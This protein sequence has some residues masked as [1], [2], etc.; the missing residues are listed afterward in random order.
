[1]FKRK[2]SFI[3]FFV[4]LLTL[5]LYHIPFFK[6]VLANIDLATNSGRL[7]LVNLVILAVCLNALVVYILFNLLR[8]GAKVFLALTFNI[9]AVAIYFINTYHVMI[10][11][12]MVG[13]VFNT[14]YGEASSFFSIPLLG[15]ILFLG[16]IPSIIVFKFEPIKEHFKSF[17]L[18]T[19]LGLVLIGAFA[20]ANSSSWLWID[21]H[22]TVLG[23]LCMPWSYIVNTCRYF[24]D[25]YQENREETLLPNLT[26]RDNKKS[27]VVLVIGES[28]RQQNFSLYGYDKET[29][30]LL[31]QMEDLHVYKAE[32]SATYTTAG[33][34]AILDYKDTGHYY[35]PL[36]NYLKRNGITVFWRSSNNGQPKLKV[37]SYKDDSNLR[38]VAEA[39]GLNADYDEVLLAGL[40][41]D[42]L[43]SQKDKVFVVLH[44]S[45]SHGPTY[46][47]KYPSQFEKFAPVCT[48]VELS[49]CSQEELI[50]AYDNTIVYTDY[51]LARLIAE[52]KELKDYKST[53]M[54]VSDHGESLG[55]SNLYM[56]GVPKKLAP[57]EQYEIPFLVW[58]SDKSLKFKAID[59]INQHFVFHSVLDFLGL[60]SPI[61]NEE[62]S[63]LLRE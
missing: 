31:G 60:D 15:Y 5:A 35:E 10:D 61:Y 21:K 4:S 24:S 40:K 46:A 6:F 53:V 54:F 23:S 13:N 20:F 1:M 22:A 63:L 34:K 52:V 62:S 16:I 47:K 3:A 43:N 57:K 2:L 12:S 49:K 11:K 19:S 29:N 36:P 41:E 28:A 9:N 37:S 44:T 45:T 18:K 32:S 56:H 17:L 39:E 48:S 58:S 27:L 8:S 38:P 25:Q 33:V 55:E 14:N 30:P 26:I 50:N 7:L 51:L 42:V 59:D